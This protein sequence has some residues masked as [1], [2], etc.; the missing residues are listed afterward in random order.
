MI[1]LF[2]LATEAVR[3]SSI[4]TDPW[5][6]LGSLGF[7]HY[8]LHALLEIICCYAGISG[9]QYIPEHEV[10]KLESCA[11][12]LL[13][14]CSSGSLY[15]HGCYAPRG[16]PLCYLFAG[17]P[18]IVANLWEVTDKDI[19]RFGK[20]MLDAILRERSNVSFSC[21]QCDT[22]SDQLDSLKITDRKR[23]QRV[24]TK[25]DTTPDMCNMNVST[26]HCNHRPKIG[27]FMG[28]ARGA[29][30]LPFLIGAAPVC[31]G[32]PTGIISKKDL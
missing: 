16:A 32:V 10:K 5:Y 22:I 7:T 3:S 6:Y 23:T 1:F 13:M 28:Q 14:G 18:V 26:N 24:K 4:W 31:Y 20:S 27:S 17:S 2:T 29:C 8:C 25:K 21:D 11:A 9:T 19:D 12:T 15:L 30:T